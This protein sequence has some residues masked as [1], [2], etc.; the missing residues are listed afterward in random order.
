MEAK[1]L[2]IEITKDGVLKETFYPKENVTIGSAYGADLTVSNENVAKIVPFIQKKGKGYTLNIPDN[3]DGEIIKNHHKIDIAAI[4]NTKL[5]HNK[6]GQHLIDLTDDMNVELK[7]GSERIKIGFSPVVKL[8]TSKKILKG[9]YNGVFIVILI[10]SLLI[11]GVSAY[12]LKQIELKEKTT[13]EKFET[14]D[15]RFASL[16]LKPKTKAI[17]PKAEKAIE[18]KKAEE[19]AKKEEQAKEGEKKKAAPKEKAKTEKKVSTLAKKKAQT[20]QIKSRHISD[21]MA[22]KVSSKGLLSAMS[23]GGG[24][25]ASLENDDLW[26][27]VDTIIDDSTLSDSQKLDV[28]YGDADYS[29]TDVEISV[30]SKG[31][32]KDEMLAQKRQLTSLEKRKEAELTSA[33]SANKRKES[34]V[35]RVVK[36]NQGGLKYVY[37]KYLRD[38]P[39]L[40]GV[41]TVKI[42][43]TA[44]GT[45]SI[46]E[47]ISTPFS[48]D[49]LNNALK[50]RI[51]RWKFG[52]IPNS[53][54]Y[55]DQYN[56][57]FTP[58]G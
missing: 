32:S 11:H 22:A 40:K 19:K 30:G 56:F 44:D 4:L 9:R 15:K 2:Y 27:S 42:T 49:D 47:V 3:I 38:D 5:V 34:Q 33:A 48:N 41:F 13:V 54:D 50:S 31:K 14:M 51:K 16:I 36:K 35:Y 8:K 26:L 39:T 24:I 37:N 57:D 28:E 29:A 17:V 21:D 18:E 46:V 23:E 20:K 58:L 43:I 52:S 25:F 53:P 12:K 1:E 10:G 7:S 55:T 45:V 6:R